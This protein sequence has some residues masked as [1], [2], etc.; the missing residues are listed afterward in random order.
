MSTTV[1]NQKIRPVIASQVP[2]FFEGPA[3]PPMGGGALNRGARYCWSK[4]VDNRRHTHKGH[5]WD[6]QSRNMTY[7]PAHRRHMTSQS[8]LSAMDRSRSQ[9]LNSRSYSGGFERGLYNI[10]NIR[11]YGH[12][13]TI[14]KLCSSSKRVQLFRFWKFGLQLHHKFHPFWE[15]SSASNE[16][17]LALRF[18]GTMGGPK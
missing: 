14:Y 6:I 10:Y 9:V 12:Y 11:M 1:P 16:T 7:R 2:P 4:S 13:Y 8:Y 5:I 3:P 15:A 18:F 17:F